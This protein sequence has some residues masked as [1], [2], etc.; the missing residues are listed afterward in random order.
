MKL[1]IE[2]FKILSPDLVILHPIDILKLKEGLVYK[3]I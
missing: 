3:Y 2:L 1:G